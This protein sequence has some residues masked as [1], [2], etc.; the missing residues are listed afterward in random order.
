[1]FTVVSNFPSICVHLVCARGSS[2]S[3]LLEIGVVCI[4]LAFHCYTF[5]FLLFLYTNVNCV[6]VMLQ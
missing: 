3:D 1:M 6:F 5:I 2:C 4:D